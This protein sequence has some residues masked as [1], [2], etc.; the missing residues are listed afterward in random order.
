MV[1]KYFSR[2]FLAQGAMSALLHPWIPR[3]WIPA[4]PV[5]TSLVTSGLGAN[6]CDPASVRT[7]PALLTSAVNSHC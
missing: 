3:H 4:F 1:H 6:Q 5:E 2:K 7:G